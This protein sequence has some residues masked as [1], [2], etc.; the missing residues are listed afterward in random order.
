MAHPNVLK[1]EKPTLNCHTNILLHGGRFLNFARRLFAA[2]VGL[3][4]AMRRPLG[5][6]N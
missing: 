3:R 6:A 2:G 4:D 5:S 1:I